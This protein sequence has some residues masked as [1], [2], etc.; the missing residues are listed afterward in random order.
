MDLASFQAD[1]IPGLTGDEM[2]ID[3]G[4]DGIGTELEHIAVES[5]GWQ[6]LFANGQRSIGVNFGGQGGNR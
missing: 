4:A 1:L 5:L 3:I 2:M 6:D